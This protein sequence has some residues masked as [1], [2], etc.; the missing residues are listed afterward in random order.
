M[1]RSALETALD[2]AAEYRTRVA[3]LEAE[4][5]RLKQVAGEAAELLCHAAQRNGYFGL[6][7]LAKLYEWVRLY[8]EDGEL[9]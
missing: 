3:T 1:A 2:I 9:R 4:N 8:T 5:T 6:G 7:P